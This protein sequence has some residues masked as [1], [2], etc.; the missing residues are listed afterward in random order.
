MSATSKTVVSKEISIADGGAGRNG[1]ASLPQSAK[2][3]LTEDMLARFAGR[4][5]IYDR[6]NRFFEEDFEELRKA[7]YLLLPL[8]AEFGGAGMTLAEV[9]REQ[10]RL[11]YYAPATAPAVNMHLYWVSRAADLLGRGGASL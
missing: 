7:K 5:A 8:P 10:R 3:V 2:S 11:A 6:E 1:S 4:A 9:C